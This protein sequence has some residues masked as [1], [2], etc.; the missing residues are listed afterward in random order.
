MNV[1]MLIAGTACVIGAVALVVF[2]HPFDRFMRWITRL[3]F[4]ESVLPV[5]K[6]IT[7]FIIFFAVGAVVLGVS[8]IIRGLVSG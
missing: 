5:D 3:Q 1:A 2:R 8:L 4:G 7:G 6:P